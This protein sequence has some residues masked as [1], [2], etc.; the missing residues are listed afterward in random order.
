MK[1]LKGA[2]G[3]ACYR[4]VICSNR[5]RDAY[6]LGLIIQLLISLSKGNQTYEKCAW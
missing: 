3:R 1:A 6:F 5:P 2:V 4:P